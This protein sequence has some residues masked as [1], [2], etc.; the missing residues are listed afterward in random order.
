MTTTTTPTPIPAPAPLATTAARAVPDWIVLSAALALLVCG[1]ARLV[2]H[3]LC[4]IG[5]GP[6]VVNEHGVVLGL[7]NDEW[8]HWGLLGAV[9]VAFAVA[10]VATLHTGRTAREAQPALLT[11]AGLLGGATAAWIWPLYALSA[12]ALGAGLACLAAMLWPA[13]CWH[14]GSP[15]RRRWRSPRGSFVFWPDAMY[16]AAATVA[17]LNLGLTDLTVV[18]QAVTWTALGVALQCAKLG[19]LSAEF[20][21]VERCHRIGTTH[22]RARVSL[23]LLCCVR[24]TGERS[25]RRIHS[26]TRRTAATACSAGTTTPRSWSSALSGTRRS[27]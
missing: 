20:A 25:R 23:H 5:H 26:G 17:S 13:I 15:S 1:P 11:G 19:G 8:S 16:A 12:L 2:L 4:K 24:A 9:P 10:V 7:T 3:V 14:A 21:T 22:P 18:A 27:S 6:T